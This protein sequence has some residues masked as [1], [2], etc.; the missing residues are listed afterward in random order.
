MDINATLARIRELNRLMVDGNPDMLLAFGQEL[1][2][3]TEFMDEW[4]INGGFLPE[5]W[6]KAGH[7]R[8][9]IIRHV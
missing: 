7:L 4:F 6:N 2:E 1:A 9:G 8:N 3:L 5:D